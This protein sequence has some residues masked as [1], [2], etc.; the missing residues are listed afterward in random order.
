MGNG[1]EHAASERRAALRM[2][3]SDTTTRLL[4]ALRNG[5]ERALDGL[6]PRVYEELH[7]IA[8]R[9]LWLRNSGTLCTTVLLHEAYVKLF[10]QTRVEVEDRAHF[11]ALAAKTMRH[12]VIDE[13]RKRMSQKRGGDWHRITL[14]DAVLGSEDGFVDVIEVDEA[15]TRLERFDERLCRIVECRFFGGMTIEETATALNV[16]P[17]TIDRAWRRAK[18]WLYREMHEA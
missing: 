12:I 3:S 6:T 13:A 1:S 11:L 16:A 10:D 14:E 9:E 7:R 15:L 17:R 5:D 2:S 4:R 18:A 8:H